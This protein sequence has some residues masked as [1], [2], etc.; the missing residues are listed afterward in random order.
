MFAAVLTGCE[1]DPATNSGNLDFYGYVMSLPYLFE[2]SIRNVP[3]ALGYWKPTK[4]RQIKAFNEAWA[5]TQA[6]RRDLV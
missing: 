6:N 4:G 3:G 5:L 1:H 2:E